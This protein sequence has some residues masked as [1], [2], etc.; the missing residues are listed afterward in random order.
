MDIA[1]VSIGINNQHVHAD[2]SLKVMSKAKNVME[3]QGEQLMEMLQTSQANVP[4]P[5]LGNAID[6]SV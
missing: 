6:V 5:N 1:A 2:A 3:Q 4:H